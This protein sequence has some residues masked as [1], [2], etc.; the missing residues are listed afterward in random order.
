[1]GWLLLLV[2]VITGGCDRK[3]KGSFVVRINYH[4]AD[5]MGATPADSGRHTTTARP[6]IVLEEVPYGK[7]QHP[8]LLDSSVLGSKDGTIVLKGSGR[9]E[10]VY[11]VVVENGP[12]M[13]L[14]NDADKIDVDIDLSRTDNYYTISGSDGSRQ[15]QE[16]IAAY[17]AKA[18][19]INQVFTEIDSLKQFGGTDSLLIAATNRKNEAINSINAYLGDFLNKTHDP[20]VTLFALGMS[21]R[22]FQN[23]EF[24]KAL[25]A[26]VVKFPTHK[27]LALLKTNYEMEAARQEAEAAKMTQQ[28]RWVGQQ[29]PDLD[30]PSTTGKMV[31]ISSFRGKYLLVDFWAS[32]CDPCRHENPNVVKAYGEFKDRNFAILGVSLDKSKDDWLKAIQ[33]DQLTW[34]HIS[35]LQMWSSKAVEVFKFEGIPYNILID[36]QGK[37]IAEDLRG[38]LLENKLKEVLK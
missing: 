18:A 3:T 7:D 25:T 8:V 23:D 37:V 36:P 16:F 13:L 6:A 31:S 11:Q 26:A 22:S 10:G 4:N 21:L 28:G 1:M 38:E 30:L 2:T 12:A 29:A 27:T 35:D 15:L 33:Q 14:V 24:E 9:E 5:K 17:D 19:S 34:T 32:W 20:A